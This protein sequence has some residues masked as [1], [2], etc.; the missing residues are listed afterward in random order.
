V[1]ISLT[2][3]NDNDAYAIRLVSLPEFCIIFVRTSFLECV[4][5]DPSSSFG[6]P[7]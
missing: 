4:I 1:E 6:P 2:S 7:I 5:F 3:L